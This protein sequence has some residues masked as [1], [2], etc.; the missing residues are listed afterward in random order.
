MS[1]RFRAVRK[2]FTL[3]ELSLA[4]MLGMAIGAM[5]LALCNQQLAFLRIYRAQ[6]FLTEEA[7]IISMHVSK[8][9]GKAERFRLHDSLADALSGANPRSAASPVLVLN[10]RQPDG[11]IRAGILSF[12]NR[13]DSLALYYYVVP[14]S[15]ALG[16]PLWYITKAPT[17]VVFAVNQGILRM[18][19]SGPNGELVTYSGA[20]TQ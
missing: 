10:F 13:N 2:G 6:N 19:L 18:T 5:C 17:D 20:M 16:T 4:I 12:E 15:G 1:R 11:V 9:V 8:L 7:P 3:V 14:L